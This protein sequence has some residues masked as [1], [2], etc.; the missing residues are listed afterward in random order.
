MGSL[1]FLSPNWQC[2]NTEDKQST[3]PKQWPVLIL[4]S[5]N[6]GLL[7]EGAAPVPHS[8]TVPEFLLVS[9]IK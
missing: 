6:T 8:D 4:T 7:R 3:D 1:S 2:Q 5:S 9:S